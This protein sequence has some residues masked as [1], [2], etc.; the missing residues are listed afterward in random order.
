MM[1][2]NVLGTPAPQG[3]KKA[4]PIARKGPAGQ[5]VYTGKVSLVESSA[6]V[7]P[8]RE[9]VT[10]A[11]VA[12]R[13]AGAKPFHG[14]VSV[15]IAFYL[16]R[17]KAHYRA[18]RYAHLVLPSAPAYPNVKPDIDK[19][20]RSTLDALTAAKVYR[21][22]AEVVELHVAKWYADGREPGCVITIKPATVPA[23]A[24]TA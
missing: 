18:G 22:D 19:L 9:L 20:V 2:F 8:W 3:S 13:R 4:I 16:R 5:K 6:T 1:Q 21:D 17:P 15:T 11:A 12:Q 10:A 23:R 7:K 14:A 24:A